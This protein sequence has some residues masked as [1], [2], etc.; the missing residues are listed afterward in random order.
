[1][2]SVHW[3]LVTNWKNTSEEVIR[4][5]K[6]FLHLDNSCRLPATLISFLRRSYPLVAY[7]PAKVFICFSQMSPLFPHRLPLN[8]SRSSEQHLSFSYPLFSFSCLP[9]TVLPFL[10]PS[11][12]GQLSSSVS[13]S[14]VCMEKKNQCAKWCTITCRYCLSH[15]LRVWQQPARWKILGT[16]Y[17]AKQKPSA[18]SALPCLTAPQPAPPSG[19]NTNDFSFP[20]IHIG[21]NW[22]KK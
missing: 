4:D 17:R 16:V 2:S 18:N 5:R 7:T 8:D 19:S 3:L 11:L 1:M 15:Q 21:L 10:A 13:P 12:L 22:G 6:R 9:L 14:F 20:C